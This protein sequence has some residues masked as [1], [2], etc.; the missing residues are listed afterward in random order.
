MYIINTQP[1]VNQVYPKCTFKKVIKK[2]KKRSNRLTIEA[3]FTGQ[4][5]PDSV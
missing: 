1:S 2:Q 4:F 5:F 3:K